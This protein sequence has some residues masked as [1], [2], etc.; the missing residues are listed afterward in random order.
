[1]EYSGRFASLIKPEQ[2]RIFNCS[3]LKKDGK[4][5]LVDRHQFVHTLVG[6]AMD[7]VGGRGAQHSYLRL[8]A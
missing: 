8:V 2:V 4:Q 6:N 3:V 1:M 7:I 5:F